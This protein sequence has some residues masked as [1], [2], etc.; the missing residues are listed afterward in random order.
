MVV[1]RAQTGSE[2]PVTPTVNTAAPVRHHPNATVTSESGSAGRCIE[3]VASTDPTA[4]AANGTQTSRAETATRSTQMGTAVRSG[5]PWL[6]TDEESG[7]EPEDLYSQGDR[8]DPL[9]TNWERTV[10]GAV[11]GNR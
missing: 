1:T 11:G 7:T 10:G 4:G 2:G 5:L 3:H 6:F 8:P 9:K